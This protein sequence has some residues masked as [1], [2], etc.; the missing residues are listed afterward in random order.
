MNPLTRML[1]EIVDHRLEGAACAGEH[2]LFDP[3]D[4]NE[5][6]DLYALRNE[7]ARA[8]CGVCPVLERCHETAMNMRPSDRTGTWAGI[9]FDHRGRRVRIHQKGTAQ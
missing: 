7:Y 4:E 3:R 1:A 2:H 6:A 9:T 5:P 8:I